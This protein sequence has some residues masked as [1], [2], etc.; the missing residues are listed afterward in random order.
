VNV[1]DEYIEILNASPNVVDLRGWKLDDEANSGASP[2][3]FPSI[4]LNPGQRLVLFRSQTNLPLPDSGGRI[5]LLTPAG[6]VFDDYIYQGVAEADQAWCRIYEGRAP[7]SE[8]C[9]PT[10]GLSNALAIFPSPPLAPLTFSTPAPC[11]LADLLP[12]SL[13]EGECQP[14]GTGIWNPVLWEERF[15]KTIPAPLYKEGF[16]VY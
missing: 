1:Y 5:R 12:S 10:P 9:Y 13:L 15:E 7:W 14:A 2:Y 8:H 4:K 16:T 6:L 11:S 3:T